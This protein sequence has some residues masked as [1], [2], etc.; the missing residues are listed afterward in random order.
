MTREANFLAE[1]KRPI[2]RNFV[3]GDRAL[4]YSL[5]NGRPKWDVYP[6]GDRSDW[7]RRASITQASDGATYI[8]WPRSGVIDARPSFESALA[9]ALAIAEAQ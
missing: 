1:A 8:V 4:R 6:K 3:R 9:L 2:L 7:S 5:Q